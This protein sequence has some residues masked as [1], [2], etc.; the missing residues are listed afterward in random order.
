[1][2]ALMGNDLWKL[3]TEIQ[4]LIQYA[5]DK[6]ITPQNIETLGQGSSITSSIF[7]LT[8]ALGQK[9]TK[10]ALSIL[11]QLIDQGEELPMIFAMMARQFRLIIEVRELQ[12]KG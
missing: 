2:S 7:K 4:K 1:M 12:N 3:N 6:K 9:K 10:E 11:H 8:D 5:D